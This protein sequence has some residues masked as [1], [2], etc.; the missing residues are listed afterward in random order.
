M[1]GG[2][3]LFFSSPCPGGMGSDC[4]GITYCGDLSVSMAQGQIRVSFPWK[5]IDTSNSRCC[6]QFDE[7]GEIILGGPAFVRGKDVHD[8][9]GRD[10][11]VDQLVIASDR[12]TTSWTDPSTG[13]RYKLRLRGFAANAANA[14]CKATPDGATAALED[15]FTAEASAATDPRTY[16]LLAPNG[17]AKIQENAVS[18]AYT[19]TASGW[20]LTVVSCT[21]GSDKKPLMRRDGKRLD[22]SDS[23]GLVDRTLRL[24]ETELAAAPAPGGKGGSRVLTAQVAFKVDPNAQ[25]DTAT[26]YICGAARAD[27]KPFGPVNVVSMTGDTDGGNSNTGCVTAKEQRAFSASE[28][29]GQGSALSVSYRISVVNMGAMVC[30]KDGIFTTAALTINRE[31]RL[32]ETRAPPGHQFLARP[33]RIRVTDTDVTVLNGNELGAPTAVASVSD[34]ASGITNTLAI[35]DIEAAAL[36]LSGS[37]GIIPNVLVVVL[38]IGAACTLALFSFIRRRNASR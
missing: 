35:K 13:I 6:M 36:P 9:K 11:S 32:V 14:T 27:G 34:A 2:A 5:E 10:C 38:A 16:E 24:D 1:P 19:P 31:Y 28:A 33:V 23:V 12:S 4:P 26:D 37:H 17:A 3:Q 8:K 15:R 25:G 22:Q 30:S 29:S 21:Y 20:K 18:P 7:E